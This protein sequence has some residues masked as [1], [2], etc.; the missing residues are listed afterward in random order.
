MIRPATLADL[1]AL[2]EIGARFHEEAGLSDIAEYVSADCQQSIAKMI[3]SADGIVIVAEAD[4]QIIGV[5]GGL[6]HPLYFNFGHRSGM[7]LFWWVD[8]PHRNGLGAQ[9]FSALENEA[10]ALG[11]ESWMMIALDKVQPKATGRLYQRRGYRAS[12]HTY[13][14]RF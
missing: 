2:G 5:A 7:E 3:Q 11:C 8:P 4:G 10:R 13:I 12:E 6:A 9:L 14:K 1:P